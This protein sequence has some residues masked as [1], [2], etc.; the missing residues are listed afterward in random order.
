M[1]ITN[2]QV[3]G[4]VYVIASELNFKQLNKDVYIN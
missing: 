1:W 4:K 3:K 2:A